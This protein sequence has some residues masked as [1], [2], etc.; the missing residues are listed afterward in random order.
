MNNHKTRDMD[1]KARILRAAVT[2]FAE[3]GYRGATVRG[4]VTRAGASNL[5]SVVYY[6]GGKEGLYKAVLEFMFLEADKFRDSEEERVSS[7]GTPEERLAGMIRFLC[8]AIYS[9][10]NDVD[11]ALYAIFV[12]EV[13]APTPMFN[14][15][16]ERYLR[17]S[18]EKMCSL[19]REFLG[20][21]CPAPPLKPANTAS[22][23]R[24]SMVPW[25][26][27]SSAA[28]S[29]SR[30]PLKRAWTSWPS[31]WCASPSEGWSASENEA[32]HAGHQVLSSCSR[33][34]AAR[35]SLSC[36]S[37]QALDRSVRIS[38]SKNRA[39]LLYPHFSSLAASCTWSL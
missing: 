26:G 4:I 6:F 38:S 29:R 3:Q 27:Q 24:F 7:Y 21:M 16:V 25:A 18:K 8:R 23:P 12:K 5:N 30:R 17:P 22:R 14:E 31:M 19:L 28:H 15:M 2:E 37:A 35:P 36:R 39:I 9:I 11:R 32:E 10:R 34:S 33:N 20:R 1:T 13:G